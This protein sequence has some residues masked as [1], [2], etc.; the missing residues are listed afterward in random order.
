MDGQRPEATGVHVSE[1]DA[2]RQGIT[3]MTG[4]EAET[5]LAY[6][7]FGEREARGNSP[8]YEEVS[9]AIARD[10][11][12]LARIETLPAAKRQPNLV[13]GAAR[14]LNAPETGA[15]A[16]V[17]WMVE[18]WDAVE[19]VVRGRA[20]QTNEAGRCA[21]L[22]PFVVEA[23]QGRPIALVEMGCSAG[24]ALFPDLYAYRFDAADGVA[25]RV[26]AGSPELATAVSGAQFDLP[27]GLPLVAWRGG[28]DLNPLDVLSDSAKARDNARWL[29]ALV[30]PGQTTRAERLRGCIA[31]VRGHLG[32]HPGER[33]VVV[34]GDVVDD[35]D[36]LLRQVP[37]ELP[38][39]LFHSAVLAY[40]DE[41]TR[42]EFADRMRKI[43]SRP[44]GFTWISNE[45]PGVMPGIAATLP[46]GVEVPAGRF[47][48]AV[49]GV[50]R[51]LVGPH[52]QA[53][54]LIVR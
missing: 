23:A 39:V 24:L 38:L 2:Q 47:V 6:A 16:F 31:T 8:L 20:T 36:E 22:L 32:T 41:A 3:Q 1:A 46:D 7:R 29:E 14:Y 21:T 40:T 10:D 33:P 25:D 49:N 37:D 13:L 5:R 50:A 54:E 27:M 19:R 18:H 45:G 44:G 48:L 15:D 35:L 26:G 4:L 52:G 34:R 43:A 53:L 51:A 42:A 12:L 28:L 11:T 9:G 17:T 30:W